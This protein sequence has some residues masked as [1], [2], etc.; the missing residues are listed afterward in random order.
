M[1]SDSEVSDRGEGVD[2]PGRRRRRRGVVGDGRTSSTARTAAPGRGYSLIVCSDHDTTG[3]NQPPASRTQPARSRRASAIA[4]SAIGRSSADDDVVERARIVAGTRPARRPRRPAAADAGRNGA[5]PARRVSSP[6]ATST[7]SAPVTGAAPSRSSWL[8]PAAARLR[9]EPGTAITSTERSSAAW[10]VISDPPRSRLS[11]TT[12]TSLSAARMRLRSGKRNGSGGVPGGHSD[13]SSAALARPRPTA[14]RATA[15]TGGRARCRRRRPAGRPATR[16]RAAVG[17]AVDALGQPGHDGHARR[18]RGRGRARTRCPGRAWVAL[19]VPTMPT[20]RASSTPRSPRTNSTAGGSGSWRSCTGY[21]GV[22]DRVGDDARAPRTRRAH[23]PGDRRAADA[24]H[25][26]ATGCRAASRRPAGAG[27][28]AP[29]GDGERL[30]R[31]VVGE[32]R[33]QAGRRSSGRARR[34]RR[35]RRCVGRRPSR[36]HA[37]R[38]PRAAASAATARPRPARRRASLGDVP[39]AGRRA[40]RRSC[41]RPGGSGGSRVR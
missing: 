17:G 35:A 12:S 18:R 13:S 16:K 28:A 21:V 8:V 4:A 23:S 36:H 20:R 6:R 39:G 34:A 30:V 3:S 15:G 22:D 37:R 1:C 26:A 19:R 7:S 9:T 31:L 33:A 25:A 27:R 5:D 29:G 41:G 11:T 32:Q 2:A 40:D 14:A 24:R 10:A 38:S